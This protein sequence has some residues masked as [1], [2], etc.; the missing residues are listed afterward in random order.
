MSSQDDNSGKQ[1]SEVSALGAVEDA[2]DPIYPEDATAGFPTDLESQRPQEGTA[3]PQAHPEH[4][5]PRP[6]DQSSTD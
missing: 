2:D 1:V 6:G 3:G 4:G 5:R